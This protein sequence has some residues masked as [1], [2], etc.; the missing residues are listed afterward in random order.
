M[1][2]PTGLPQVNHDRPKRLARIGDVEGFDVFL[3][4][5]SGLDPERRQS[6]MRAYARAETLCEANAPY[7]LI[8]PKPI[9]AKRA[10]KT[11]WSDP[12]T[13]AKLADAF[14]R[15]GGDNEKLPASLG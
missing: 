9:D 3:A 4:A 12:V 11:S 10:Q 6:A 15:A 7:R 1:A 2:T 14:V 13:L 8:K 5:F